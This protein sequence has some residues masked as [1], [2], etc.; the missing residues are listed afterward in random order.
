MIKEI[1]IISLGIFIGL[2]I[3]PFL[4][5]IF[6]KMHKNKITNRAAMRILKQETAT[7]KNADG[8]P[9]T[10]NFRN[11]GKEVKFKKEV[12]DEL[13]KSKMKEIKNLEEKVKSLQKAKKERD[14]AREKIRDKGYKKTT[15]IIK[16][17]Y[18]RSTKRRK[19]R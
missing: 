11:D 19:G 5:R 4:T 1:I 17:K 18:G 2:I 13:G 14:K 7:F 12:R 15:K 6:L 10:L 16:N 9:V 3:A 8:K